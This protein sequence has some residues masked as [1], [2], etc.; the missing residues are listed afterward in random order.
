MAD[1]TLSQ[2]DGTLT[3][4]LVSESKLANGYRKLE[5]LSFAD[6]LGR[7]NAARLLRT[8][9]RRGDD[10][11]EERSVSLGHDALARVAF[12]WKQDTRVPAD[13]PLR[14]GRRLTGALTAL[15][16]F[17]TLQ[18]SVKGEALKNAVA[19]ASTRRRALAANVTR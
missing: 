9:V 8:T 14:P 18:L 2:V 1:L 13:R 7:A 10:G 16:A 5:G 6:L 19:V 4:A 17:L 3:T 15:F 12:P 11:A